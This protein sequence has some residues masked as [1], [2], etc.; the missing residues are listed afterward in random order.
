MERQPLRRLHRYIIMEKIL[1]AF[2]DRKPWAVIFMMLVLGPLLGAM[3]LG[4][5]RLF[6]YYLVASITLFLSYFILAHN[7]YF[8]FQ[9]W[10]L[11][12]LSWLLN[13]I[14]ALH[15]YIIV[16]SNEYRVA[17]KWF[18]GWKV[19][20][21]FILLPI[22]FAWLFRAYLYEPFHIPATSMEPTFNKGDYLF[23][24]KFAYNSA[25]PQ[26]EDVVLFNHDDKTYIKRVIALPGDKIII[27]GTDII[28]NGSRVK[29]GRMPLC[30]NVQCTMQEGVGH[31]VPENQYFLVGDNI[32]N[33]IDSRHLGFIDTDTIFAKASMVVWNMETG[34]FTF[35][36]LD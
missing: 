19:L 11:S 8:S 12:I 29:S 28:R 23:A 4:K 36:K 18:S 10:H 35:R 1:S 22:V 20:V 14:G 32:D 13:L 21:L 33:S 26:F 31:I 6:F 7:G 9:L 24:N 15:G 3:Y 2:N 34:K 16:S 30:E 25:S 27:K 17:H 5:G